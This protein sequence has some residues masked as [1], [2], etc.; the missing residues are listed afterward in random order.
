MI[1]QDSLAEFSYDA[2]LAQL[3][4]K[5][6]Y[7]V[8]PLPCSK[9]GASCDENSSI[10]AG[11]E[12]H[13]SRVQ[14]QAAHPSQSYL[15]APCRFAGMH[16]VCALFCASLIL[17]SI[18][19][20]WLQWTAEQ[21]DRIYQVFAQQLKNITKNPPYLLSGLMSKFMVTTGTWEMYATLLPC[22][23]GYGAYVIA[24]WRELLREQD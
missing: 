19:L 21:F 12:S 20:F 14:P 11:P 7:T 3:N 6:N 1:Y 10:D 23:N 2:E 18:S 5:V 17:F 4:Y 9:K 13:S 22:L 15:P 24:D 16:N 8:S